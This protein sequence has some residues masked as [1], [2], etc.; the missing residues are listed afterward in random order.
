MKISYVWKMPN[1]YLWINTSWPSLKMQI[2]TR[3]FLIEINLFEIIKNF[4]YNLFYNY[5][6]FYIHISINNFID[7]SKIFLNV[8]TNGG[9]M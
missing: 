7:E 2:V 6:G 9:C 3:Y 8:R 4:I 1:E 5:L